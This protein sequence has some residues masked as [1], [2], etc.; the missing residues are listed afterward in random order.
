MLCNCVNESGWPTEGD[1]DPKLH[2]GHHQAGDGVIVDAKSQRRDTRMWDGPVHEACSRAIDLGREVNASSDHVESYARQAGRLH[3]EMAVPRQRSRTRVNGKGGLDTRTALEV[4]IVL[5]LA[6][7][8]ALR[9][10]WQF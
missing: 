4:H 3:N 8:D 6:L 5:R 2:D 7:S 10:G 9:R 1:V